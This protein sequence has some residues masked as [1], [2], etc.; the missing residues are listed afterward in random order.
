MKTL[1]DVS[2]KAHSN[3]LSLAR[4]AVR[5]LALSAHCHVRTS[6][7]QAAATALV[8][9]VDSPSPKALSGWQGWKD[10]APKER[11]E[12]RPTCRLSPDTGRLVSPFRPEATK[13][14][15]IRFMDVRNLARRDTG[16]R[17]TLA[18]L[19]IISMAFAGS[20]REIVANPSCT[21][22]LRCTEPLAAVDFRE[23]G[24]SGCTGER[25]FEESLHATTDTRS[26]CT[27]P[28][29]SVCALWN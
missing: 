26:A 27:E 18:S 4:E 11:A 10:R 29:R 12:S 7:F 6:G 15:P 3:V 14:G 13:F 8:R 23:N 1:S 28:V 21:Q 5:S 20:F 24:R 19:A 25:K 2:R 17:A 22:L 16:P 9:L